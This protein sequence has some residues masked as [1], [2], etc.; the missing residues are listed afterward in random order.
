[1][2]K[3]YPAAADHERHLLTDSLDSTATLLYVSDSQE[4][5][6]AS[7]RC[8]Y[9]ADVKKVDGVSLQLASLES[10]L[11]PHVTVC[12]RLVVARDFRGQ[13]AV[14]HSLLCAMYGWGL[15]HDIQMNL[16]HAAEPLVSFFRRLGYVESGA[17]F[18]D[19]HSNTVQQPM[20][21]QLQD[22]DHLAIVK[23]PFASILERYRRSTEMVGREYGQGS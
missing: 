8:N 1:M 16:C 11:E 18:F 9:A 13:R 15:D 2:G 7:V 20:K 14:I 23:S 6:V 22:L 4:H 21:L 3:P 12:S 10:N 17:K 5:V 19:E